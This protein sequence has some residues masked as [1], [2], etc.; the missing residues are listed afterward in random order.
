MTRSVFALFVILDERIF[1]SKL[2][3]LLEKRNRLLQN[4]KNVEGQG[5]IRKL[6][7]KI[8]RLKKE[9]NV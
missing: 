7:R 8:R 1:M 3:V 2:E 5:V 9:S 6:D 4:G